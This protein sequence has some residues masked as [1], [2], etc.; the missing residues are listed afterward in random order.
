MN[1]VSDTI[2]KRMEHFAGKRAEP[3]FLFKGAVTE[4]PGTAAYVSCYRGNY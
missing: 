3:F 4:I 1:A 2:K